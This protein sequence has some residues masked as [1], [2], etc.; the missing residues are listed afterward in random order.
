MHRSILVPLVAFS[1]PALQLPLQARPEVRA[2]RATRDFRFEKLPSPA[3]DDAAAKAS[4]TLISGRRDPNGADVGALTDGKVPGAEDQ[5][6]D[7]FFFAAGTDGGHLLL[8][9][10]QIKEIASI[11]T[12]SWHRSDRGPQ[13]Y[14][15]YAARGTGSAFELKPDDSVDPTKV[16]WTRV[17][18]VDTRK[19]PGGPGG[20]HA[21]VIRD[22]GRDALGSY[23]Y[24]L[25]EIRR[26]EDRDTFGNTF[27]SEIDVIDANA[28]EPKRLGPAEPVVKSFETKYG[29]FKFTV[30]ATRS[31]DLMPWVEKELIPVVEEWYPKL[32]AM[33]PSKGYNAPRE[34]HMEFKDDMGGTPAYAAGNRLSLSIPFFHGQLEGEAKGCVI[35]ELVHVVQDYWSAR[36]TNRRPSPTPG[37]VTEGIADYVRWFLYEP[38][39]KGA[40]ITRGN[41]NSAKYDASYR[42]TGNFFDWVVREHH[43][44]LLKDLNAAAREGRY[45]EELWKKW[46]GKTVGE[47]GEEWLAQHR[48]RLDRE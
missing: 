37:W 2:E 39:S 32:C 29:A 19:L 23:R 36:R 24:L 12:Y 15:L 25:F 34:V 21:A 11:A 38:Q 7:N 5:P 1:L 48:K 28:P 27:F 20:Q 18:E 45:D 9:L 33:M 14:T 40:E 42:I 6:R 8:D 47:L 31:P 22:P 3:I 41:L 13:V 4:L 43:K 26:T 30:D 17:A 35:H 10:G 16:G 44:D 46:T